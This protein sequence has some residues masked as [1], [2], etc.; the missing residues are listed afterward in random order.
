[1]RA[2]R[3]ALACG[4]ASASVACSSGD[5]VQAAAESVATSSQPVSSASTA[6][7]SASVLASSMVPGSSGP[8]PPAAAPRTLACGSEVGCAILSEGRVACWGYDALGQLG[9]GKTEKPRLH[10]AR[11][12]SGLPPASW[13]AVGLSHV[14]VLTEGHAVHC[15]GTSTTGEVGDGGRLDPDAGVTRVLPPTKVVGLTDHV[16]ALDVSNVHSCAVLEDGRVACW[17]DNTCGGLGADGPAS[18]RPVFVPGITDAVEVAA[19]SELTCVRS[20]RGE[21]TCWGQE[22][23]KPYGPR[24]VPGVCARQLTVSSSMGCA[25]DCQGQ[26][27]CW[28]DLPG[29]DNHADVPTVIPELVDIEELRG[30]HAHVLARDRAGALYAWGGDDSGQLGRGKPADWTDD[31]ATRPVVVPVPWKRTVAVAAGGV[32][33]RGDSRYLRPASYV[34]AGASC[35][36]TESGDVYGWGEPNVDYVP[37]KITLPR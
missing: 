19:G 31:F 11:A 28:G 37:K 33:T 36:R 4:L 16:V 12:V 10:P 6:A 3:W 27:R 23:G 20:V 14:C 25:L 18:S 29:Y 2:L 24:A 21:V 5:P 15:W 34:D 26:V 35:A 17:G 32:I 22:K 7:P 8:K 1:M 30:G 13:V 9:S